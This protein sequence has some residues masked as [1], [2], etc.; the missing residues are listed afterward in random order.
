[1]KITK[2]RL[3]Q[4]LPAVPVAIV[5]IMYA[6][7]FRPW[8]AGC[9]ARSVALVERVSYYELLADG[10]PVAVFRSF[11]DSLSL[12]GLSPAGDSSAVL[13]RRVSGCWVNRWPLFASCRGLLLVADDDSLESVRTSLAG[14]RL[15]S[16]LRNEVERLGRSLLL[17][18]K[19]EDEAD[20]YMRVHNVVDDGYNT[21]AAYTARVK[22]A[23]Q[24]ADS[25][26]AA[27]GSAVSARRLVLRRVARYVLLY[28]DTSGVVVRKPCVRVSNGGAG[29]FAL[30]QT[31]D[32]KTVT[33]ASALYLHQ[34]LVP[35]VKAGD[36]VVVASIPGCGNGER[37]VT[38]PASATFAGAATGDMKHGVPSLLAPDGSPVFTRGG[39]FAGFS[40]G[41]R[42]VE[43]GFFGFGL[44]RLLP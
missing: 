38:D 31:A 13:R 21:V 33:G 32:R 9:M 8:S 37:G 43:P 35:G 22:A 26:Y 17:M 23:R 42:V 16:V 14:R 1:M 44:N 25:L 41:D 30:L 3:L 19:R 7:T 34:W 5:F 39:F 6:L 40:I 10:R 15:R 28:N 20:Y 27:L 12:E 36:S 2:K 18:D 29:R 4:S 24:Q 11:G